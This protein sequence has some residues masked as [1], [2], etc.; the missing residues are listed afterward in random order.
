ML[1]PEGPLKYCAVP[2][3]PGELRHG[4]G[5][6]VGGDLK[7]RRERRVPR[8]RSHLLGIGPEELVHV[9]ILG[10]LFIGPVRPGDG[11]HEKTHLYLG[12]RGLLGGGVAHLGGHLGD[13]RKVE[14][15]I[16]DVRE[17]VDGHAV[18]EIQVAGVAHAGSS[19]CS[20]LLCR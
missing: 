12:R 17:G 16:D 2:A 7:L 6:P 3:V 15:G 19:S 18:R 5:E 14:L 11:V 10:I 4:E 9:V 13:D 8:R 1:N 20:C